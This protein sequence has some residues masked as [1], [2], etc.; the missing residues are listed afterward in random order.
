M[1]GSVFGAALLL[2]IMHFHVIR[3]TDGI[4][5]IVKTPPRLSESFVD[6]RSFGLS[7]W[8]DRPLLA[9]ALVRAD[10]QHLIG[11][12]A[13]STIKQGMNRLLPEALRK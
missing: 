4:D 6:V 7:D 5:V 1:L 2:L 10:K 11:D 3:S 8:T 9:N 13:T 12:S